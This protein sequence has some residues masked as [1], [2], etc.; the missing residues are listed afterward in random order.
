MEDGEVDIVLNI[1]HALSRVGSGPQNLWEM[2]NHFL[3]VVV[4]LKE[5]TGK[6]CKLITCLI[7]SFVINMWQKH[8]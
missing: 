8:L 1:K 4:L 3:R 7:F 5:T 6:S 2:N